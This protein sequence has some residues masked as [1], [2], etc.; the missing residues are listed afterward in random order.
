[1]L[2]IKQSDFG[3]GILI[4]MGLMVYPLLKAEEESQLLMKKS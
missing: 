3:L 1:M 4:N 2:P